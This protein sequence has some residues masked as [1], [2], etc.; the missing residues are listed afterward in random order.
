MGNKIYT[1]AILGVGGRGGDTYGQLLK[2]ERE[3]FQ[4][5]SLCDIR[6]ERLTRFGEI[7][8][9]DGSGLFA[10]EKEFFLKKRADLLVIATQDADHIR[11]ARKAFEL[12]YDILLEKPITDKRAECEELLATQRKYGGKALVCHVL[13]YA[14]AFLKAAEI[15][16]SGEIGSLVAINALER[17]SFWHQ[18]HSYVRGNWR[19]EKTAAPMI[20][21]KCCHDLDLLQWYAR[22]ACKS[23][24]SV[25]GLTFFT[26]ENAPSDS[27]ERCV[28]C[29]RVDNCPY[30]AK[31]IYVTNWEEMGRVADIWPHN[32]IAPA[33]LTKES[34]QKAIETGPYGRCVFGCDN[35]VVDHQIVTMEFENGVKAELTMTAF[36]RDGGRR[37]HFFGTY[38]ELILDMQEKRLRV[39]KYSSKADC[40]EIKIDELV[41]NGY[42]H[43]GGDKRL[44][45]SLYDMLEGRTASET[46]LQASVESHLIGIC[47]EESRKKGGEKISI[48]I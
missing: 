48:R 8:G 4:I 38:G 3:R 26:A 12:G 2:T 44:I 10:D 28:D 20:L 18:A 22:S 36:T 29:K 23:V 15:I 34:L 5:V 6:P 33:P 42:G 27:A 39:N 16:D 25:G 46:S 40:Y 30:S 14:P 11:H 21:A 37:Y 9:V 43:G 13:R 24:S 17:V 31:R 45:D 1:V 35:D 32:I 41:E 19:T 7:L 47:A